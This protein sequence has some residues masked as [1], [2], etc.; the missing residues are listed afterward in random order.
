MLENENDERMMA[1]LSIQHCQLDGIS[2]WLV[3]TPEGHMPKLAGLLT[4]QLV[5][6]TPCP[7]DGC[8]GTLPKLRTY[9]FFYL[10]LA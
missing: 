5:T 2:H 1:G 7:E 9:L 4:T 10:R 8:V 6:E 3:Y